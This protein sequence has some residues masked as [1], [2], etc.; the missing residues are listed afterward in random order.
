MKE[1]AY[2]KLERVTSRSRFKTIYNQGVW[3]SSQNFTI[4][5]CANSQGL[6]RLGIT[7]TRKTGNAVKRN[8]IKRLIREFYRLNKALFPDNHD[9][10]IMAKKHTPPLT[11]KQA[12]FELTELFTRKTTT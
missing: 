6:K 3:R 7:V 9:V 8:K 4:V 11:F 2:R 5:I 10:V 1:Q 12:C